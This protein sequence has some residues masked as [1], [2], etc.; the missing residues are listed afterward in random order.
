MPESNTGEK[1]L[2]IV[3]MAE[4]LRTGVSLGQE[5]ATREEMHDRSPLTGRR[6]PPNPKQ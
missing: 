3:E 4:R 6:P 2:A 1:D 5:K